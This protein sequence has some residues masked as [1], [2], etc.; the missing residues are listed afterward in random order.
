MCSASFQGQPVVCCIPPVP[1]WG[2]GCSRCVQTTPSNE[3]STA[4]GGLAPGLLAA[5]HVCQDKRA[6]SGSGGEHGQA[7]KSMV[8][9]GKQ[10]KWE[11]KSEE[12][13]ER[14][15][16]RPGEGRKQ[17]KLWEGGRGR[18]ELGQQV[19]V[20]WGAHAA[21]RFGAKAWLPPPGWGWSWALV[22]VCGELDQEPVRGKPHGIS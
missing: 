3:I 11:G 10:G 18:E 4:L 9:W 2:C 17:A 6:E 5:P 7:A 15:G 20:C 22:A 13:N 19:C 8:W 21:P 16:K 1:S 14:W 12:G